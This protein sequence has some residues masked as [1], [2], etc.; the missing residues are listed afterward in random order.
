MIVKMILLIKN[1]YF[2]QIEQN[3]YNKRSFYSRYKLGNSDVFTMKVK[4]E[5]RLAIMLNIRRALL[6]QESS[7]MH[8]FN[9]TIHYP[10]EFTFPHQQNKG[11]EPSNIVPMSPYIIEQVSYSYTFSYLY[12]M[13]TL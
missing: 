1:F 10:L 8:N 13:Y 7:A 4:T 11:N 2:K 6:T 12:S 5:N 9:T 3:F